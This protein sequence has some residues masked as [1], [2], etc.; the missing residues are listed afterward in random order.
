MFRDSAVS[1]PCFRPAKLGNA[2]SLPGCSREETTCTLWAPGRE[3]R[4]FSRFSGAPSCATSAG[5]RPTAL[6]A[7]PVWP[8]GL[9]PRLNLDSFPRFDP[10]TGAAERRRTDL[11]REWQLRGS[12]YVSFVSLPGDCKHRLGTG[13]VTVGVIPRDAEA[14]RLKMSRLRSAETEGK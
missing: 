11:S 8:L 7:A 12:D 5:C 4:D 14:S 1:N 2:K 6:V 3:R 13:D 9:P 10:A